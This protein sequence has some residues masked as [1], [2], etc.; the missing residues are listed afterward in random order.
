MTKELFKKIRTEKSWKPSLEEDYSKIDIDKL[1]I[2]A[3]EWFDK[4]NIQGDFFQDYNIVMNS[5]E[6]L[7]N[8][9][10]ENGIKQI[11]S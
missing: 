8:F 7:K 2:M 11:N 1:R 9:M 10:E 5:I 4:L 6:M 3:D